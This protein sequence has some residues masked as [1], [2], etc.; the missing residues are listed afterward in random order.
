MKKSLYSFFT[1]KIQLSSALFLALSFTC[2]A[3]RDNSTPKTFNAALAATGSWV[4]VTPSS[5]SPTARH[6]ASFVQA[7]NK[8]YLLG[9][10]GIKPVQV[11]D[12]VNKTWTNKANTPI[13]LH[14]F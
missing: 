10:R 12:P 6:E 11:F 7:G 1:Q 5:G 14:H 2:F 3:F 13:E 9:G 4:S 8:F